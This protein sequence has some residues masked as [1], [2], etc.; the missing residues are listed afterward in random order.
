V[1]ETAGESGS[2]DL[3]GLLDVLRTRLSPPAAVVSLDGATSDCD[4]LWLTTSLRGVL[5]ATLAVDV[6]ADTGTGLAG[7]LAPS[8][9]RVA[10]WLLDRVEC[11]RTGRVLV[12]AL[13]VD[14]PGDARTQAAATAALL[15]DRLR[16]DLAPPE[17]GGGAPTPEALA[18]RLLDATWRP[19]LAV[20]GADGLPPTALAGDGALPGVA[21]AL[22]VHL[23]PTC[24]AEHAAGAL[25]D[26]LRHDAPAGVR[27][28]CDVTAT[29]RGWRAAPA[30]PWLRAALGHAS[31]AAFGRREATLGGTGAIAA[32]RLLAD[33]FPGAPVVVTGVPRPGGGAHAPDEWLDVGAAE[34]VAVALAH[35][36]AGAAAR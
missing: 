25:A 36:L 13:H 5:A 28:R 22:A 12:D 16:H 2:R 21:L 3:P 1:F 34:R 18:E 4:R 6:P 7:A 20:V 15:G 33:A 32:V 30:P 8:P 27:V 10:R 17:G 23:P 14:L 26:A 35:L 19:S 29:A 31:R 9:M 24:D 11:A